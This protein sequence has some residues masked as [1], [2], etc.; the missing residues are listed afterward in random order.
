MPKTTYRILEKYGYRA[1]YTSTIGNYN[2]YLHIL[3]KGIGLDDEIRLEERMNGEL[4]VTNFP[5][6]KMISSHTARRSAIT[7][8][9]LRGHNIHS[10]KRCSGHS[11]L[12]IFDR[13]IR[14]E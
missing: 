11:D 9:V 1:P 2:Y 3:M 6:W 13:Y 14:D 8:N 7:I 10:I 5:K 12:R 4:I